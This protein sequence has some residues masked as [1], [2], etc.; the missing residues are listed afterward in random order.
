MYVCINVCEIKPFQK[1]HFQAHAHTP[2][3]AL[4][5]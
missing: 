4:I 1:P 3:Y 5:K 2:K